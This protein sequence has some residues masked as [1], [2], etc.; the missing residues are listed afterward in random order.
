MKW[1]RAAVVGW[2]L[3]M[4]W[5][6]FASSV[7]AAAAPL[8][9]HDEKTDAVLLYAE[10]VTTVQQNGKIKNLRRR[11]FKILRPDGRWYGWVHA[12]FDSET[13]ITGMRGWCIPS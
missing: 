1:I 12:Y 9:A 4:F 8:P 7:S 2:I 13:K 5:L 11:V 3:S 10:D 6:A